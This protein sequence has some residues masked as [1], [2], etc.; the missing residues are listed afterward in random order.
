MT[1]RYLVGIDGGG[2]STRARI[3]MPDGTL[4]G[5][6]RAGASGLVQGIGQAWN[7][8][9]LA[10]EQAAVAGGLAG[11]GALRGHHCALGLGLAGANHAAWHAQFLAANPGYPLLV[12]E[13][14]VFTALLGA[15]QG[16]P[17]AVLISG[18]GSIAQVLRA[19]GSRSTVGGWGFPSGD[20]GS[21]S[22][23]G[24]GAVQ[25]AQ[26]ALDGRCAASALTD[27]VLRATGT[28]PAALLAWCSEAGQFEFA[29]LAPWV[30]ACEDIDPVA[31]AL[32]REATLALQALAM[33]LDPQGGLPV[34]VRG[35]IGQR[36]ASRF[37]AV[38]QA[39]L[40]PPVGDAV[41]GALRLAAAL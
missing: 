11:L 5:E 13:S 23:L 31:A 34:A 3:S 14:D 18:T 17:G 9:E 25:R 22:A 33:A 6:G 15:H 12:L 16:Q 32:L 26:Q 38:L 27:A 7:H 29:S 37:D 35:S 21:G 20:E 39:R 28:T 40:V 36:L 24:L 1:M 8:I 19:D 30:F 41:D 4:V 2:T 10:M